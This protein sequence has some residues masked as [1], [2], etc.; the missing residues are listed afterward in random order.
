MTED[1]GRQAD[2][3]LWKEIGKGREF[4]F[5]ATLRGVP[6]ADPLLDLID[7]LTKAPI[8]GNSWPIHRLID[9]GLVTVA[10]SEDRGFLTYRTAEKEPPAD[11]RTWSERANEELARAHERDVARLRQE[12]KAD[13]DALDFFN[14]PQRAAED[15]AFLR[16]LAQHGLTPEALDAR[17]DAAVGRAFA[18]HFAATTN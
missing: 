18:R 14:A 1:P 13:Q 2:I 6:G 10:K 15:A 16:G 17:I 12:I 3:K 11:T 4:T 7:D 8:R 9:L 5:Q